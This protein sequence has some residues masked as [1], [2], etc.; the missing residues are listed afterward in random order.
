M[1]LWS[2]RVVGRYFP[3]LHLTLVF[4]L[5]IQ[6]L[7]ET[8][9]PFGTD[10]RDGPDALVLW[11][12]RSN[13]RAQWEYVFEGCTTHPHTLDGNREIVCSLYV[14]SLAISLANARISYGRDIPRPR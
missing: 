8:D 3:T 14:V 11:N 4:G 2:R 7:L 13:A 9:V 1:Y 6:D 12:G 10:L 5:E